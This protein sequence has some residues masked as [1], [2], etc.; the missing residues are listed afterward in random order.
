MM[1]MGVLVPLTD[2]LTAVGEGKIESSR[3]DGGDSDFRLLGGLN[4]R[5]KDR[6]VARVALALGLTDGAPDAQF[7]AGYA[8]TF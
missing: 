5:L 8:L 3:F 4:W 6:G 7:L 1:G 2:R